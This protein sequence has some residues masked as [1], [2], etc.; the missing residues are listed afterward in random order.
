[1]NRK[2]RKWTG[3]I[4]FINAYFAILCGEIDFQLKYVI[5]EIISKKLKWK[6]TG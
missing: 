5:I 6:K 4:Q 3:V 1:M 2:L